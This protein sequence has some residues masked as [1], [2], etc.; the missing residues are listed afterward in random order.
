MKLKAKR[1]VLMH[2]MPHIAARIFARGFCHK[3]C[4][5]TGLLTSR[6]DKERTLLFS[7]T[8]HGARY[9]NMYVT[10]RA[11]NAL[12]IRQVVVD[13]FGMVH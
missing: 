9:M 6:S 8:H 13:C 4:P 11:C 2:L 5:N 10:D 1:S 7:L 3:R 12:N